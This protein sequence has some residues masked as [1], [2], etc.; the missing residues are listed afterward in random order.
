MHSPAAT[1]LPLS[2]PAAP[3]A[4]VT[5]LGWSDLT[6]HRATLVAYA[7]RRLLDPALAED[8]VHDVFEAVMTGR[9]SFAGRSALRSWLVGILKH[10]IVDLVRER[11][12]H[13][14][15]DIDGDDEDNASAWELECPAARPDHIAEQRQLLQHTL[16]RIAALPDTLRRTVE[17][18]L[19]HD[20][21]SAEVCSALQ[22]SEQNLFVRLHRARRVLAS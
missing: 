21:S 16:S 22:I 1:A 15:L 5:P 3:I 9:A 11:S 2:F 17:L 18:R 4:P 20:H 6:P 14:S 13:C 7:R 10:K 12:G 8:L 19:L